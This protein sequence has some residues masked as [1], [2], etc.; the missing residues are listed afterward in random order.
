L[1]CTF[2]SAASLNVCDKQGCTPL[3]HA[4]IEH[5][6][7]VVKELIGHKQINLDRPSTKGLTPLLDFYQ[8]SSLKVIQIVPWSDET[9]FYFYY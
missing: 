7:D 9:R 2:S 6:V 4:V 5:Q 8:K 1:F 3:Y